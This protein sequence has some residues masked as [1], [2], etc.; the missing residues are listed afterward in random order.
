M[1][2]PIHV[3]GP[4]PRYPA[5][6]A[7]LPNHE[8]ADVPENLIDEPLDQLPFIRF[9]HRWFVLHQHTHVAGVDKGALAT[10]L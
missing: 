4:P 1:P 5:A 2:L 6:P 8:V 3:R 9:S 7:P 10:N